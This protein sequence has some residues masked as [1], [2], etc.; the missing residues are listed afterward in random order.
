MTGDASKLKAER[1]AIREA[2]AKTS[3][4]GVSGN[5]CF[6]AERDAELGAYVIGVKGGKRYLVDSHPAD[7]C[8]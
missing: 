3:I 7:K 1:N 4:S 5:I 6:D 2:L 8:N